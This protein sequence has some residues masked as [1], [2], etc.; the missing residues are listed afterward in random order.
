MTAADLLTAEVRSEGEE[1]D[2]SAELVRA[3]VRW[4]DTALAAAIAAK[5]D[6][7]TAAT[8]FNLPDRC[9]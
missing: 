4:R 2:L 5:A 8:V 1:V 7:R 9:P 6:P 3:A